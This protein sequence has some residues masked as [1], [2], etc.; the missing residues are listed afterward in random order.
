M[1]L[2]EARAQEESLGM[3]GDLLDYYWDYQ[4]NA[5]NPYAWP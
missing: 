2:G 5:P 4:K 3:H 1:F